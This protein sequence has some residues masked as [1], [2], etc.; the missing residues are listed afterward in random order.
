MLLMTFMMIGIK[1]D[2]DLNVE[3]INVFLAAKIGKKSF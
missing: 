3:A 1:I 2:I